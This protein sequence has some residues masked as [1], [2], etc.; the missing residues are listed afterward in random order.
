MAKMTAAVMEEKIKT[1]FSQPKL[2]GETRVRN[3]LSYPVAPRL[4]LVTH[5]IL[6][7]SESTV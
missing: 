6:W 2:V 5:G 4:G 1:E 3:L 7:L